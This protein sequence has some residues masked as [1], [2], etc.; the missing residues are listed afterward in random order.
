MMER[1]TVLGVK[2]LGALPT[3]PTGVG[4]LGGIPPVDLWTTRRS[5]TRGMAR[6]RRCD[7]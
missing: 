2:W 4:I 1:A 7:A 5:F 3:G 6:S